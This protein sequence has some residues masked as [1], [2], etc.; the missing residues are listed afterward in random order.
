MVELHD[1]WDEVIRPRGPA[2]IGNPRETLNHFRVNKIIAETALEVISLC[3]MTSISSIDG[4]GMGGCSCAAEVRYSA[5]RSFHPEEKRNR[6]RQ[7]SR[8]EPV[9]ISGCC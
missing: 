7:H 5:L 6:T 8:R 3:L 2:E 4:G 1:I 9:W